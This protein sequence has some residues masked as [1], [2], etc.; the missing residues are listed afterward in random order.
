M[1]LKV[2][3]P[4]AQLDAIH[5]V[6]ETLAL[7]LQ[8]RRGL[9]AAENRLG[10]VPAGDIIQHVGIAALATTPPTSGLSI[11]CYHIGYSDHAPSQRAGAG[12]GAREAEGISL[13]LNFL[14][15]SWGNILSAD[16]ALLSWAMLELKRYP[17]LDK[18]VLINPDG[19]AREESLRIT[20][21]SAAPEQMFRIWEALKL[22]HRLS[23]LFSVSV[24]RI[25]YGP[26]V[27]AAP[28]VASRLQFAHGDPVE[29]G[30]FV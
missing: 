12:A 28:V 22:K 4:M 23:A 3:N 24:V 15:A 14:M 29:E 18:S 17:V 26:M 27:D 1:Q 19:W 16:M 5:S 2:E 11:S 13:E 6:G 20:P 7:L 9:L 25:G 10:P 21:E 30:Q 8:R